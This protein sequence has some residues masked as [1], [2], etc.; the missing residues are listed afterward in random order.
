M[1]AR[2]ARTIKLRYRNYALLALVMVVVVTWGSYNA[3]NFLQRPDSPSSRI[4]VEPGSGDWPMYQRDPTHSGFIPDTSFMPEG[5]IHWIFETDGLIV[6]SP[7]VVEGA[8]YLSTSNQGDNKIVSLDADTGTLL[9]EHSATAPMDSSLAVAGGLVF[10][11]MRDGRLLALNISDGTIHWEFDARAPL[12]GSPNVYR[13]IVYIVTYDKNLY[14]LDAATGRL[15]WNRTVRGRLA[16]SLVV[17]DQII[18]F[19]APDNFVY[20][21]DARTGK[22]RLKYRTSQ[23]TGSVA[24]N[25]ERV[26][27]AELKGGLRAIDWTKIHFPLEEKIRTLRVNLWAW[28]II[29]AFPYRKGFVWFARRPKERFLGTPTV[30]DGMVYVTSSS[31]KVFKVQ[32]SDGKAVWT[33]DAGA[34]ASDSVSVTPHYVVVGDAK[35]RVHIIDVD[36]G[37]SKQQF[38]V[39]GPITSAPVITNDTLYVATRNGRLYAIK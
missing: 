30:A 11:T 28:G 14:L 21:L 25:G 29:K 10:V 33:F 6:N 27:V 24:L 2:A 35:G 32:E 31:G 8:V 38:E 12:F 3:Y 36:K 34:A 26:Y 22:H 20:I 9:W 16:S 18:A 1:Q 37:E 19:N 13:G 4:S 7:V 39:N 17:N 15:L 23:T 5:K